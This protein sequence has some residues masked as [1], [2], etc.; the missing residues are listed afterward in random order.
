VDS[1]VGNADLFEHAPGANVSGFPTSSWPKLWVGVGFSSRCRFSVFF[2]VGLVSGYRYRF[3][4]FFA[5]IGLA[6]IL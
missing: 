5:A 3:F 2:Q 4:R 1:H 6:A